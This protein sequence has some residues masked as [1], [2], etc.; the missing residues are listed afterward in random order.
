MAV[1]VDII[2]REGDATSRLQVFSPVGMYLPKPVILT[3][4]QGQPHRVPYTWC[5][6]N[7]CIAGTVADPKMVQEMGSGRRFGWNSS[8]RAC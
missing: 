3:V 2:E 7:T 5:L 8:I 1:R 6:A 4:D